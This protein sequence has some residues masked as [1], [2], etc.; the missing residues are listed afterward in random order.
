MRNGV[1][2][3]LMMDDALGLYRRATGAAADAGGELYAGDLG[4][5]GR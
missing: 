1:A 5:A 2:R 4:V 3:L